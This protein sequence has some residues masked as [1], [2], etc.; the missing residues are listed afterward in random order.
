MSQERHH[1]TINLSSSR[2]FLLLGL[3]LSTLSHTTIAQVTTPFTD[4]ATGISFQF[5]FGA[6]T[7]FGF[8]IALPTEPTT[9]FIGQ[10][11]FPLNGGSGWGGFS[12]TGDVEGPLLLAA[13]SDGAGNVVSSFRQARNEDDNP[14][15]VTGPFALKPIASGIA[16]N[17]S[18]LTFTFLCKGCLD[19]ALGLGAAAAA[20]DAEMG[21]A[22]ACTAVGR[23]ESSAGILGFHD[24]GFGGVHGPAWTGAERA[25]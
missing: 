1:V 6:R 15:E 8:G 11:T 20:A 21:W 10:L 3:L 16:V 19:A 9:D 13:W 12:L 7:Q 18:F 24:S 23:P 25:V 5:F 22:L 4:P 14:P 17:D 2:A